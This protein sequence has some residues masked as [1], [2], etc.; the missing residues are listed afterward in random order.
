MA[1]TTGEQQAERYDLSKQISEIHYS[2][3]NLKAYGLNGETVMSQTGVQE[4][5]LP[6][7]IGKE[8]ADKLLAQPKEGTLRSL[9][10]QDLKVGGEGMKGFYDQILV[11]FANKFVKKYGAKVGVTNLLDKIIF[12]E[13]RTDV[14]EIVLS[15]FGDRIAQRGA[16]DPDESVQWDSSDLATAISEA[17]DF[18]D[19]DRLYNEASPKLKAVMDDAGY[20]SLPR[21]VSPSLRTLK[22]LALRK[23]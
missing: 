8:A 1:W 20:A 22:F 17:E 19:V 11:R 14:I 13:P 23:K 6:D 9:V 2:G 18:A 10:G 5:E 21:S 12:K 16:S 7:Y 3:T 4:S 15:D